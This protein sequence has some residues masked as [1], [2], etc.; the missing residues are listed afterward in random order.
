MQL[1]V[2]RPNCLPHVTVKTS[3]R[4]DITEEKKPTFPWITPHL[5]YL[6]KTQFMV[7][8]SPISSQPGRWARVNVQSRNQ[9]NPESP[10]PACLPSDPNPMEAAPLLARSLWGC[11]ASSRAQRYRVDEQVRG[12]S[13]SDGRLSSL[14][15]CFLY[16]SRRYTMSNAN[17]TPCRLMTVEN[18]YFESSMQLQIIYSRNDSGQQ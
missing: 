6:Q 9:N 15:L 5:S 17:P 16:I 12:P 1:T 2:N 4:N 7:V 3:N 13:R 14:L 8:H 18:Q 10:L 11:T